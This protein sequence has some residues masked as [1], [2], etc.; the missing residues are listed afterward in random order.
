MVLF[1]TVPDDFLFQIANPNY[2]SQDISYLHT[3]TNHDIIFSHS[4][5][6]F[7]RRAHLIPRRVPGD[8]AQVA[9]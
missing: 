9:R 5:C 8:L 7:I 2:K 4:N 6:S 1:T 3:P